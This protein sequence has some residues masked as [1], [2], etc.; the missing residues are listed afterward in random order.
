MG[1]FDKWIAAGTDGVKALIIGKKEN[2]IRLLFH[3]CPP[4]IVISESER[5]FKRLS[6]LGSFQF[7]AEPV[8]CP[9]GRYTNAFG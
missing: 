3:G 2:D 9:S 5:I 6:G 7:P 4:S 1:G 8:C